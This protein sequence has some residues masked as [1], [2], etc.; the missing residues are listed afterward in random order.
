M[1]NL[2]VNEKIRVEYL[3]TEKRG[4]TSAYRMGVKYSK[5][6]YVVIMDGDLSHHP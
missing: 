6:K 4:L 2:K 5:S 3:N 1:K